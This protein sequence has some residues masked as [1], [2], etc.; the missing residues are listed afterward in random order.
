MIL[1]F[2]ENIKL[3]NFLLPNS[4]GEYFAKQ[5]KNI[6]EGLDLK[7]IDKNNCLTIRIHSII[8]IETSMLD[9]DIQNFI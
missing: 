4:Y 2:S 9:F 8:Y 5:I 3:I 6:N 7:N 1:S